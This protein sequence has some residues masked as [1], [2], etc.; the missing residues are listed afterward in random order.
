MISY[1]SPNNN[2]LKIVASDKSDL[3]GMP[4]RKVKTFEFFF[5]SG[6]EASFRT[7]EN[8]AV[9]KAELLKVDK[10]NAA[11]SVWRAVEESTYPEIGEQLIE[12][13]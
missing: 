2:Y 5:R 6:D 8:A 3:A 10:Y 4:Q 13:E 11:I 7:A 1:M 12:V 9:Y